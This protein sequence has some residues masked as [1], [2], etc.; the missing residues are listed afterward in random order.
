[1]ILKKLTLIPTPKNGYQPVYQRSY[2]VHAT[3]EDIGT[4]QDILSQKYMNIGLT[5]IPKNVLA[6]TLGDVVGL[7]KYPQGHSPVAIVNG[8]NTQRFKFI[9]EIETE[10]NGQIEV[11]VIQG[12]TSHADVSMS[13]LVDPNMI[14]YINSIT[15]MRKHI[16][17]DG[18][19]IVTPAYQYNVI[20]DN[21]GANGR[22][23]FSELDDNFNR[24][25]RPKDI[26]EEIAND[27]YY[28]GDSVGT[29]INTTG[30]ITLD[31]HTS[32][33]ANNSPVSY[34][35]KTINGYLAGKTLTEHTHD[36]RDVLRAA[37]NQVNEATLP[38]T[39]VFVNE[40]F[41]ITH[42]VQATMFTIG[43]LEL[44]DPNIGAKTVMLN[45]NT[46]HP[47]QEARDNMNFLD[48]DITASTLSPSVEVLKATELMFNVNSIMADKLL[49]EVSFSITN[50]TGQLVL[51]PTDGVSFIDGLAV[52]V[53][54]D[55]VAK[56]IEVF[57]GP[58]LTDYGNT[59]I[60]AFVRSSLIGDSTVGISVNGSP[61]TVFRFPA[62]ADSLFVPVVTDAAT[63]NDVTS[64]MGILFD[65]ASGING[66][67]YPVTTGF[68][69]GQY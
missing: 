57:A 19:L 10:L 61:L 30:N 20:T 58:S 17:P 66:S 37:S 65:A 64:Q 56:H 32:D 15:I 38:R 34:L 8:W 50:E 2:D 31:S 48:T 7:S 41:K 52:E 46:Y 45:P 39:S 4:L 28:F 1:M 29:V 33:R 40:L 67:E 13:G 3:T 49:A 36:Q 27:S 5:D 63:R 42:V 35:A 47:Y 21:S 25:I 12:Y 22:Y 23:E 16:S 24:L 26:I 55:K 14:L 53:M 62:F 69:A 44:M 60:T 9:L 18:R 68:A 59:L 51:I 54:L 6:N 43:T 11:S